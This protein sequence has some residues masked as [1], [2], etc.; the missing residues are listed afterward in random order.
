MPDFRDGAQRLAA[1]L[2][3]DRAVVIEGGGHLAS[4]E[5]PEAFREL[6]TGF[7]ARLSS[8]SA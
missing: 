7:L 6:L 1:Q 3:L 5:Q 2:D 4:L 8:R